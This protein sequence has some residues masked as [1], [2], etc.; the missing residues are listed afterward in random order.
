MA[1][2]NMYH[3]NIFGTLRL[4]NSLPTFQ[5]DVLVTCI[6]ECDYK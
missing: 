6:I 5:L 3:Y 4:E 1:T 2:Q